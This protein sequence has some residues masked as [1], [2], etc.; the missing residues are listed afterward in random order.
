[1]KHED[2][3]TL[4]KTIE[5]TGVAKNIS[6]ENLDELKTYNLISIAKGEENHKSP[7]CTLTKKG[8]VMLKANTKVPKADDTVN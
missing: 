5:D 4:L 7:T 2:V 3:V 1:M 6:K 8:R